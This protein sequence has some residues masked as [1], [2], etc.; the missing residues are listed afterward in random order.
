MSFRSKIFLV[1]AVVGLAPL[2]VLGWL[3]FSINRVELE[4]TVGGSQA[5]MAEEAARGAERSLARAIESLRLSVAIL[6]IFELRESE[7]SAALL[8]PYRQLDFVGAVALIGRD[9]SLLAEPAYG[10]RRS[11]GDSAA[12]LTVADVQRFLGKVPLQLALET[13]TAMSAPYAVGQGTRV[14]VALRIDGKEPVAV[15]AEVSLSELDHGMKRIAHDG[16]I[17]YVA[18]AE[19]IAIA[20]LDAKG[21]LSAGELTLVHD[22][23]SSQKPVSR[24]VKRADGREWLAS[25]SPV[26]GVGWT[27]VIAQPAE[28]AFRAAHRVRLYTVYWAVVTAL[29]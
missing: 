17:A 12:L 20:G 10:A 1:L 22:A 16:Q 14:A 6:P 4:K 26:S 15:A 27:V 24:M 5:A 9:G 21:P 11:S 29:L 3:S 18:T 23:G 2:L 13:G 28:A 19:G 7:R 8:I 25:A